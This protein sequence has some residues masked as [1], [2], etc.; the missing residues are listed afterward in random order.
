MREHMTPGETDRCG[1]EPARIDGRQ[2][3]RYLRRPPMRPTFSRRAAGLVLTAL[4]AA[5][6]P[7]TAA[8][9]PSRVALLGPSDAPIVPR[10]RRNVASMK[11]DTLEATVAV[12]TRDVVTRLVTELGVDTAVCTDGDQ[13]GV[14]L[15][16]GDRLVLK[17]AVVVQSADERAHELAAARAVMALQGLPAKDATGA[18]ESAPPTSFTIVANGP[19]AIVAG[20]EPTAAPSESLPVK[21]APA[22]AAPKPPTP[23]YAPRLV[24]G[25]GPAI[26]ASRDGNSFAISAEAEIGLGRY[27]ALVPWL[28]FVPANRRAE[29]PLGTASFRPTIFGLGFGVPI[30]RPSSVVVPR[31]GAGYGVLWMHV[32]PE[33]ATAPGRMGKPEDLLAPIAY[34]TAAISVKVAESF[35]IAGEAMAGVSSHDMI[36]RIGDQPAAHWGVPLASLALRGEWVMQ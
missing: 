26:A 11:L 36:V 8:A 3:D 14:W 2:A 34:A 7:A 29:A 30:L 33:S 12:C 5:L 13:I 1:S 20:P 19:N 24:L 4:A 23:R 27:V 21:D 28:Q 9:A 17:E 25:A 15:R 6:V 31:V 22:A 32:S 35:R 10:L 16:E 18:G